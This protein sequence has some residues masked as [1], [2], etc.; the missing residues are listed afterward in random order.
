MTL[1]ME[2]GK[3]KAQRQRSSRQKEIR[4]LA[5]SKERGDLLMRFDGYWL[6]HTGMARDLVVLVLGHPPCP[7]GMRTKVRYPKA[8]TNS[9]RGTLHLACHLKRTWASKWSTNAAMR[10]GDGVEW[11][12]FWV[13]RPPEHPRHANA[14]SRLSPAS[15]AQ[16]VSTI[17]HTLLIISQLSIRPPTTLHVHPHRPRRRRRLHLIVRVLQASLQQS[18][19]CHGNSSLAPHILTCYETGFAP[20]ALGAR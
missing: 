7:V 2:E 20:F 18:S 14:L 3:G 9:G 5:L 1:G 16:L 17:Q 13:N 15:P 8:G 10:V 4:C 11:A 6:P 19:N 12:L